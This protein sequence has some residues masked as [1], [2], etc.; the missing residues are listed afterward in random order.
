MTE[1]LA[2]ILWANL[3]A[4]GGFIVTFLIFWHNLVVKGGSPLESSGEVKR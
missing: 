4:G 3:I 1:P 2:A